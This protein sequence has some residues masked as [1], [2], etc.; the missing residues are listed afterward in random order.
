M[1]DTVRLPRLNGQNRE[2]D[3]ILTGRAVSAPEAFAMGLVNRVVAK[4]TARKEAEA[5]AAEIAAFPQVCMRNDRLSAYEQWDRAFDEAM[6]NEFERGK[7]ALAS[8]SSEG[9]R[10]FVRRRSS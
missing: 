7:S 4:G 3:L 5:L 10:R 6:A 2:K 8:E 9:A 1:A